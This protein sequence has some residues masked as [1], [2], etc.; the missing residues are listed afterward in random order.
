MNHATPIAVDGDLVFPSARPP[1]P[2]E[3]WC[4]NLNRLRFFFN[5]PNTFLLFQDH[6]HASHAREGGARAY[7][8]R[9]EGRVTALMAHRDKLRQERQ[10]RCG[11]VG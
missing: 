8:R 3:R 7:C 10:V 2:A 6:L 11:W 9:L 5:F 4:A 1:H